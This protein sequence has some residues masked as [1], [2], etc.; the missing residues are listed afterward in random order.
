MEAILDLLPHLLPNPAPPVAPPTH[1]H[2]PVELWIKVSSYLPR[3]DL[4]NVRLVSKHLGSAAT[5]ALF[6]IV[7][8]TLQAIS[9]NNLLAISNDPVLSKEVRQIYYDGRHV[10]PAYLRMG[11]RRWVEQI[12][13]GTPFMREPM[14]MFYNRLPDNERDW[15]YRSFTN[16][17][18][19]QQ[20][21]QKDDHEA[22]LLHLALAMFTGLETIS[23]DE[24]RPKPQ[25]KPSKFDLENYSPI[26]QKIF[27][28]PQPGFRGAHHFWTIVE[29]SATTPSRLSTHSLES[30]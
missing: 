30:T 25:S 20:Y 10:D 2:L 21:L 1:Y 26:A 3:D 22:A 29:A 17:V 6:N 24:S 11:H 15:I 18:R 14:I 27:F 13:Q 4:R 9:F 16:Y 23:Y 8:L 19:G 12:G 5:A 28:E 7:F